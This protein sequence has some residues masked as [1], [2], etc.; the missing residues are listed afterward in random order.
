MADEKAIAKKSATLIVLR[1]LAYGFTG[2]TGLLVAKYL[3]PAMFG[4]YS[5]LMILAHYANYSHLGIIHAMLKLI[6]FYAG[7]KDFQR[8]QQ[9]MDT[10]FLASFYLSLVSAGLILFASFF[11]L[12]LSTTTISGLR[13]V[14]VIIILQQILTFQQVR[15][16]ATKDFFTYGL[17]MAV[18]SAGFLIFVSLMLVFGLEGVLLSSILAYVIALIFLFSRKKFYFG[19]KLDFGLAFT[20][21]K[22]GFFLLT[23]ALVTILFTSIDQMMIVYFLGKERLGHYSLA[24]LIGAFISFIPGVFSSVLMPYT[25]ERYGRKQKKNDLRGLFLTSTEI[26][27]VVMPLV[28]GFIYITA[29]YVINMFFKNYIPAILA[30]KILLIGTFFLALMGPSSNFLISINRERKMLQFLA[31]SV[32]IAIVLNYL[33]IRAGFLIEGVAAATFASYTVYSLC[34]FMTASRSYFPQYFKSL[35]YFVKLCSTMFYVFVLLLIMDLFSSYVHSETFLVFIRIVVFLL[36]S[37]PI[38]WLLD[39]KTGVVKLCTEMIFSVF[40]RFKKKSVMQKTDD[41]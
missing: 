26:I 15:L 5:L 23:I 6:P 14:A 17:S 31:L 32:L 30:L 3:G 36:F 16:Q 40:A 4:I 29:S 35:F 9:I 33:M 20:L 1:Y 13:L 22:S 39:K 12:D 25:I 8:N 7:K 27:S 11:L 41:V 34:V 18:Y 24:V 10:A 2:I 28:V 19:K 21:A 38:I 37:V